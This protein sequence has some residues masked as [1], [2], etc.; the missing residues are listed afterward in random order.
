MI[1]CKKNSGEHNAMTLAFSK[2]F[3]LPLT[4]TWPKC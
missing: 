1:N 4:V 3:F 2:I